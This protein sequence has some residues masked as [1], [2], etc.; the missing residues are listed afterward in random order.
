MKTTG[1]YEI[2]EILGEGGM[3]VVYRA[4]D[5]VMAREVTLKTLRNPQDRTA[6][7]L[8]KKECAVLASMAHPNIVEIYDVGETDDTGGKRPYF[9]MPL[10]RGGTLDLLIKSS[11]TRL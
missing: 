1:R 3:G 5:P 9:V 10:L 4:F 7:D 8:F 11:S 2:R 6:L